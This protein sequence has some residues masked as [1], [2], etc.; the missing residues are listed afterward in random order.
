[1]FCQL[2]FCA[3]IVTMLMVNS[4]NAQQSPSAS[5]KTKE[6]K[7]LV[8]NAGSSV[9]NY[10]PTPAELSN[11]ANSDLLTAGKYG[12]ERYGT[13]GEGSSVYRAPDILEGKAE[14]SPRVE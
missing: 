7:V 13:E 3:A 14:A 2:L 6:I 12:P 8:Q 10:K 9:E 1:M 4:A 11:Y 5:E